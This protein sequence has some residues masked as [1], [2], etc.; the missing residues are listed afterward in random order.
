[1][2]YRRDHKRRHSQAF[3]DEDEQEETHVSPLSVDSQEKGGEET[4]QES[5][6]MRKKTEI[7]DAFREEHYEGIWCLK[8]APPNHVL[9]FKRS[10]R[11][12]SIIPASTIHIIARTR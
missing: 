4:L 12:T 2:S 5:E 3:M 10:Y 11:A 8:L 6:L 1:M 7:W 9:T